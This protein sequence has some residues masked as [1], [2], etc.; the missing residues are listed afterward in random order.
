MTTRVRAAALLSAAFAAFTGAAASGA[1]V[2]PPVPPLPPLP[3]PIPT[4]VGGDPPPPPTPTS[5]S[6]STSQGVPAS[7]PGAWA[8]TTTSVSRALAQL[9][10]A[11]INVVRRA[12]RLPRLV[13]SGQLAHAGQEHARQLAFAGYFSHDWSDGTPFGTWIRRFYPVGSARRWSAGENLAWA[14]P[15]VTARQA[16]ELWLAS[17]EHRRILLDRSWRQVGL[18]AVRADGAG[19]VYGGQSVV[20]L[21][22][23]FGIR[24]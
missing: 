13:V 15:E 16:V 3:E 20:I 6:T 17:P 14:T 23:E 10:T 18:G 1:D 21:A 8:A 11:Q 24:R 12:H 5:Q 19:G 22:A 2:G 9:V 7:A 4:L